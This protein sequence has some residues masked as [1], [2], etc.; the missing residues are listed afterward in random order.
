MRA[1]SRLYTPL[2]R[3]Q[4]FACMGGS[5]S[6]SM[7][8]LSYLEVRIVAG[9]LRTRGAASKRPSL[10][11]SFECQTSSSK[12]P[13]RCRMQTVLGILQNAWERGVCKRQGYGQ[14]Q[15]VGDSLRRSDTESLAF[16]QPLTNSLC[17]PLRSRDE[18]SQTPEVCVTSTILPPLGLASSLHLWCDLVL[19]GRGTVGPFWLLDLG[20]TLRRV[21]NGGRSNTRSRL[22][23]LSF[24]FLFAIFSC[25]PVP[26]TLVACFAPNFCRSFLRALHSF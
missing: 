26:A 5:R 16:G 8:S 10:D 6:K 19:V 11:K 18:K 1:L 12:C 13:A 2:R 21:L 3:P 23:V 7:V 24:F 15:Q 22:F 17:E 14:Y 9:F 4:P 25:A 20:H